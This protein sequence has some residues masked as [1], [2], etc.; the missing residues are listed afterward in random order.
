MT[1]NDLR[2]F[3]SHDWQ[4]A[5]AVSRR[6]FDE[7]GVPIKP[8]RLVRL[9]TN[10]YPDVVADGILVRLVATQGNPKGGKA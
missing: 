4:D 2:R 3:L 9:Y 7:I 6:I 1:S 10:T 8:E 5:A